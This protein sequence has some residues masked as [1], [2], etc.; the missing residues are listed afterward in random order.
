MNETGQTLE[1]FATMT[2]SPITVSC[3]LIIEAQFN[4]RQLILCFHVDEQAFEAALQ[5]APGDRAR[6]LG[7]WSP[8]TDPFVLVSAAEILQPP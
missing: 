7:F 3:G 1:I 4:E 2:A 6:F 5:L 8:S